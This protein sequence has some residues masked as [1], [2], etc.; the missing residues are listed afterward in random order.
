M[1]NLRCIVAVF[2]KVFNQ[3]KLADETR[4]ELLYV[5]CDVSKRS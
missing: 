2:I 1:I 4:R 5:V 3:V